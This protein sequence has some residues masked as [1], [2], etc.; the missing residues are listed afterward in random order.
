MTKYKNLKSIWFRNPQRLLF[1]HHLL[2]KTKHKLEFMNDGS[3]TCSS[4]ILHKNNKFKNTPGEELGDWVTGENRRPISIN[5]TLNLQL[6]IL[7]SDHWNLWLEGF[8]ISSP[9]KFV[10]SQVFWVKISAS[11]F[12]R[13]ASAFWV[14]YWMNWSAFSSFSQATGPRIKKIDESTAMENTEE[15][16]IKQK[17]MGMLV[18]EKH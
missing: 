3:C 15:M 18:Y 5:N 6:K 9:S 2:P 8:S 13:T 16:K 14:N 1:S 4:P 11:T 12:S 10:S 17:K 7:I